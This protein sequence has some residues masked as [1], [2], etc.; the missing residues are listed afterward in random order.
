MMKIAY[1]FLII[2]FLI[3]N[4]PIYAVT[5]WQFKTE[6]EFQADAAKP[7]D[8]NDDGID[9]IMVT[10]D[11]T[12]LIKD[13]RGNILGQVNLPKMKFKYVDALE[14]DG[15]PPI[16]LIFQVLREETLWVFTVIDRERNTNFKV[17]AGKDDSSS[18][19]WGFTIA[20]VGMAD[21]NNDSFNDFICFID[22]GFNLQPRGVWVYDYHNE[23]ELWHF[24]FGG[25]PCVK[26]HFTQY[27]TDVNGNGEKEIILGTGAPCN[28]SFANGIDDFNSY[29]VVLDCR[30][31]L[32]WKRQVGD[33]S[34]TAITWVGDIDKDGQ[35][36]IVVS[37]VGGLAENKEPNSLLILN[38]RTGEIERY[39]KTG[40]KFLGMQVCDINR[41]DRL[42]IITGNSD[43]KI[44][45]FNDSLNLVQEASFPAP[46][47]IHAACDFDG[48]GKTELLVSTMDSKVFVLNEQ[49]KA[50]VE[51]QMVSV[52][53]GAFAFTINCDKKKKILF[54]TGSN[55]PY[56][57]KLMSVVPVSPLPAKTPRKLFIVI[58]CF[59]ILTG[60]AV[61]ANNYMRTTRRISRVKSV[62]D[63][64]PY[65]IIMLDSRNRIIFINDSAIKMFRKESMTLLKKPVD[66]LIG[67]KNRGPLLGWLTNPHNNELFKFRINS[68]NQEKNLEARLYPLNGE[69][70]I[71]IE[72]KTI[73][74]TS[75]KILS[76][77]G[78]AQR[79]AHEIKNPLSAIILTLQRLQRIYRDKLGKESRKL[80]SYTNSILEEIER[81]RHTTDRFM[82]ILSFEKPIFEPN[83]INSI[84]DDSLE[85]Y[86]KILPV[87][88]EIKKS[89][90]KDIPLIR[91]DRNQIMVLLSNIIENALEAIGGAGVLNI[92]TLLT[93]EIFNKQ[94]QRFVEIDIED[95]GKGMSEENLKNLYKPFFTTKDGGTGLGLIISKQIVEGHSGTI[96]IK[97]KKGIGTVVSVL[98]P[99]EG[100]NQEVTPINV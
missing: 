41:D 78:F 42:D 82:R 99:I 13:Q 95:T 31:N 91:C 60:L 86:K 52:P 55:S 2:L 47:I 16:D 49:L 45:V 80:D 98:L 68:D 94:I 70:L 67:E 81:L 90:A 9:E 50:I 29:V 3:L 53:S 75:E 77:A 7:L 58:T 44:R 10:V 79:L 27:V 14:F 23:R 100:H 71:I 12:N 4:Y 65:S 63:L 21:L 26:G 74:Y 83:D 11:Y 6:F 76:W 66:A 1:N 35:T 46:A 34:T 24:W 51:N 92:K 19:E 18:K 69:R 59:I 96:G 36:E 32:L 57:Y 38:G 15:E 8:Y 5:E 39:I 56:T 40:E 33:P 97:S 48:D 89:Y 20:K 61:I 84:T 93:E 88:V 64:L 30:G 22:A 85:K 28:G 54:E 62:V 43:G 72:D 17:V 37:E 87:K 25:T 73:K